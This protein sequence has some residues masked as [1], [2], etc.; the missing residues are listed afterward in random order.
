VI[1]YGRQQI[2]NQDIEA[3]VDV[4]KSDWLT[5]GPL[6][7]RFE[8]KIIDFTGANYGVGVNSA[9]S[10]LHIACIALG[11]GPDDILW[12][13]PNSFVASANCGRYCGAEVDFVDINSK[14]WNIDVDKLSE[15]LA[16]AYVS[17]KLPKVIVPVHFAGQPTDQERIWELAKQYDVRVLED[18]SHSIGASNSGEKTGSCRWAD[19]AV[20]SFHPVKII[21][22][23]EGG[24]ALT[25]NRDLFDRLIL[26]RQHGIARKCKSSSRHSGPNPYYEQNLLGFNYRLSD[27]HAALGL[28][29]FDKLDK[30]ISE[31]NKYAKRYDERLADLPLFLPIVKS[32]NSSSHHLYVVR[33][34][35]NRAQVTRKK[36]FEK[37]TQNEIYVGV[38]YYPIHLQPYYHNFGFRVGDFPEAEK[39][40]EQAITLPL[41]PGMGVENQ[42]VVI[43]VL[44]KVLYKS[45]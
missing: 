10:A 39:H 7:P 42:D 30:F 27:V 23:V 45:P 24:I 1:P 5:Q 41:Y 4:L 33:I 35:E 19:I 14:T 3:V 11:L 36:V 9:T 32:E 12:T 15:K 43:K 22:A 28:S 26:L 18:C 21:T 31:R 29:Q 6:V 40:A 16:C 17:G 8:Q 2:D 34:D 13:V 25:N 20:F 44:K 38:H 37:F